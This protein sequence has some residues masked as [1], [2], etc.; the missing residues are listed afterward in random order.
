MVRGPPTDLQRQHRAFMAQALKNAP[1]HLPQTQKMTWAAAAWHRQRGGKVNAK[2]KRKRKGKGIGSALL[3]ALPVVLK[4]A[5]G[6]AAIGSKIAAPHS[7]QASDILGAIGGLGVSKRKKG[8]GFFDK[9]AL[10]PG[11]TVGERYP[12]VIGKKQKTN[13]F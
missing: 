4:I 6:A 13:C 1:A 8:K 5:K 7:K 3:K 12:A 9:L 2:A 11:M 10:K